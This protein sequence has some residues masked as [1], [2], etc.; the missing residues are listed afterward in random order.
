MPVLLG[1]ASLLEHDLPSMLRAVLGGLALWAFYFGLA[2][3]KPGAMGMGDVKLAGVLGGYLAWLSWGALVV[4]GFA[5]FLIGGISGLVLIAAGRAGR[6][7]TI[8]YG[9]YMLAGTLVGVLWGTQLAD[10]YL[11]VM[12]H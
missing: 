7:S 2:V 10:A 9:P 12:G 11:R 8:P 1:L 5:G 3:L 6:K 4:G